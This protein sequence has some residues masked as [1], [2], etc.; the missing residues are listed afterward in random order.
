MKRAKSE[1]ETMM[2][3]STQP[4]KASRLVVSVKYSFSSKQKKWYPSYLKEYNMENKAPTYYDPTKENE[5][6]IAFSESE[7]NDLER[8]LENEYRDQQENS[9]FFS[10]MIQAWFGEDP[11][12][13]ERHK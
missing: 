2:E 1:S 10:P 4:L 7:E 6:T 13:T 5:R 9:D 8:I 3:T 12:N 11:E